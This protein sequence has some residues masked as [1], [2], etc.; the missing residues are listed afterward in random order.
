MENNINKVFVS[1]LIVVIGLFIPACEENVSP[2]ASMRLNL[3]VNV[4]DTTGFYYEH[5]GS[6]LVDSADVYINSIS[7]YTNN[8]TISDS[9]GAAQFIQILP[10]RYNISA[11]K[12]VKVNLNNKYFD[13]ILNGQVQDVS[14]FQDNTITL[15]VYPSLP[16]QLLFSEIYYNG[17]PPQAPYNIPQ[18][19]HDQFTEIY[20]N[21]DEVI[22]LD[23]II[24]SDVDYGHAEEDFVYAIHAYMFPGSG[25]DYPLNPGEFV[26]VA[27]DAIDH[28]TAVP[29]SIDLSGADFEYYVG[30]PDVDNPDI[31]N[32]IK[33]HH[34]Y[35][36]DFLYSV[37]ND[38]IVMLK[39]KDPYALGYS[40]FD[41]L[42]LPFSSV[43]D[44]VDYRDNLS[45]IEYKRLPSSID[46]GLTG[47]FESY[48]NKSIQR[49]IDF[50]KGD[51]I[52]LMDNNN[53]SID[54][55]VMD[56]PTP[57]YIIGE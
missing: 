29:S 7:Y 8:D 27:Q 48:Q 21:S 50:Y 26:V 18:Y 24:I 25:Q 2:P 33:L 28:T 30:P 55:Q 40:Q 44:G 37:F 13:Y 34:K 6:D 9:L 3:A 39:V 46:A 31:P 5:F 23:S 42:L 17:S 36:V 38:A 52:I 22:Y 14:I 53:S 19:F 35:G 43:I 11:S 10:D 4:V 41:C 49:K 15:Y 56:R 12:R 54:F 16:G 57:G 20:N 1:I 51:R 45:E 47:G 32:M